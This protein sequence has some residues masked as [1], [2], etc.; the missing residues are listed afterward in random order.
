[1]NEEETKIVKAA[2]IT[3]QK[4]AK[5]FINFI[6]AV[7]TLRE[8]ENHYDHDRNEHNL[9]DMRN[10]QR[11]VDELLKKYPKEGWGDNE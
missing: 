11:K 3:V 10:A 5:E 4:K 2:T 6:E 8:I 7:R 9:S 1:M